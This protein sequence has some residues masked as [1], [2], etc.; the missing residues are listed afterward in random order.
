MAMHPKLPL[1]A[2]IEAL[3]SAPLKVLHLELGDELHTMVFAHENAATTLARIPDDPELGVSNPALQEL[4]D[5]CGRTSVWV[6]RTAD[7][8]Y[9]VS[10]LDST[11]VVDGVRNDATVI[12]AAGLPLKYD[13][14]RL[15][16]W[17]DAAAVQT[18][19]E[20]ITDDFTGVLKALSNVNWVTTTGFGAGQPCV[21][22]VPTAATAAELQARYRS[23][24]TNPAIANIV[25][26]SRSHVVVDVVVDGFGLYNGNT[27]WSC[28]VKGSSPSED[29]SP[30][31]KHNVFVPIE[32]I[33]ADADRSS[34]KMTNLLR[35]QWSDELEQSTR[36][37]SA[38]TLRFQNGA[39]YT[40]YY[41]IGVVPA[42]SI[43]TP[44]RATFVA[45]P[46]QYS[47]VEEPTAQELSF[48]GMPLTP[49][50]VVSS[51]NLGRPGLI[52]KASLGRPLILCSVQA[53]EFCFVLDSWP[54]SAPQSQY[55]SVTTNDFIAQAHAMHLVEGK[56]R[57][58]K[59]LRCLI[60]LAPPA[61]KA[62]REENIA[63]FESSSATASCVISA[64]REG[65][66]IPP[67]AVEQ[68][69][70]WS[71]CRLGTYLTDL[72]GQPIDDD[73]TWGTIR[74]RCR[75]KGTTQQRLRGYA[76]LVTPDGE[77]LLDPVSGVGLGTA[78][79]L[80]D[81][82][83]QSHVF[84]F[85]DSAVVLS[86]WTT[87]ATVGTYLFP[88]MST[89]ERVVFWDAV[90]AAVRRG[91]RWVANSHR[92]LGYLLAD[93]SGSEAVTALTSEAQRVGFPALLGDIGHPLY[94][95][96]Y[97][98]EA[99]A[100]EFTPAMALG[101]MAEKADNLF[102]NFW[103]LHF[104]TILGVQATFFPL[105]GTFADLDM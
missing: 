44:R 105:E 26:A 71:L 88:A 92:F 46:S 79:T 74:N 64:F 62:A 100:L 22:G 23:I 2:P 32:Q 14:A 39:T 98:W 6:G 78:Q 4:R 30:N 101:V 35:Y 59:R 10:N 7:G 33:A 29:Y 55:Y 82:A 73:D 75:K 67:D 38:L 5:A 69:A 17:D 53:D 1:K 42:I 45:A 13:Q 72:L 85:N 41:V 63:E 18:L 97:L 40:Y 54:V 91:S 81:G 95:N 37:R 65:L 43:Q 68:T 31:G 76:Y 102:A 21:T 52:W 94:A 56:A 36:V 61:S 20:T 89:N 28:P 19:L 34:H 90:V 86:N 103:G 47:V 12:A 104:S 15:V 87:G 57:L 50:S 80:V 84:T 27:G 11:D 25:C 51:S 16:Q 70:M 24:A 58:I 99:R 93:G 9:V 3:G 8:K 49:V 60:E 96:N 77:D 83:P 66:A 48:L